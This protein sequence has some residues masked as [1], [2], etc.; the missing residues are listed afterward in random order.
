L[1]P[2]SSD[3]DRAPQLKASVGRLRFVLIT[4]YSGQEDIMKARKDGVAVGFLK[5]IRA[6]GFCMFFMSIGLIF[7]GEDMVVVVI[8]GSLGL[9]IGVG[10]SLAIN[11]IRRPPGV[12]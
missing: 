6:V 2:A 5:F 9:G 3:A 10:M 8:C 4:E 11:K 12:T 1:F 7:R